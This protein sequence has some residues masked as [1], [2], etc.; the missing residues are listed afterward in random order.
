MNADADAA[1]GARGVC[2]GT[3]SGRFASNKEDG[4]W[5]V[6]GETWW[7]FDVR[8]RYSTSSLGIGYRGIWQAGAHVQLDK[9]FAE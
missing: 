4:V 8:E 1:A 3:T 9:V 7:G 6:L 2:V 5:I